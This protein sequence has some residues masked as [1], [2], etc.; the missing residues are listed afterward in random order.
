M[1]AAIFAK[2]PDLSFRL[3]ASLITS[4]YFLFSKE[5]P[6]AILIAGIAR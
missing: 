6:T 1:I 5:V 4:D 2:S 3:K